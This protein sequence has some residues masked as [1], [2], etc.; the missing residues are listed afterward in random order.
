MK[1]FLL[2]LSLLE[3]YAILPEKD[4]L[5]LLGK[6]S[7]KNI[8]QKYINSIQYDPKKIIDI[9]SEYDFPYNYNFIE[10]SKIDINIKNQGSCNCSWS[11]A[12]TTSLSYRFYKKG[13]NINLSPQ[14]PLSCYIKNCSFENYLIDTQL[15]LVKNGTVSEEC[16]PY[17]SEGGKISEQCPKKCKNGSDLVKYY[18]YKPYS[19]EK[20]YSEEN[21][22][23][24]ITLIMDEL[25][26]NGPLVAQVDLYQDLIDWNKNKE[27]CIDEIYIHNIDNKLIGKYFVTIIGYG[28][29]KNKFYWLVQ[30]SLGDKN[31]ILTR[32]EFGQIGIERIAFS[33]P[34]IVKESEIKKNIVLSFDKITDSCDLIIK[35]NSLI[36]EWND[37]LEI[38][39]KNNNSND[40]FY[41]QC[42]TNKLIN[43]TEINCYYENSNINLQKGSYEFDNYKSS[44]KNNVFYLDESFKY[45]KFNFYGH[46]E[47]NYFI[48]KNIYVS[49]KGSQIILNNIPNHNNEMIIPKIYPNI[50]SQIELSNCKKIELNKDLK[51]NFIFC[52]L[53]DLEIKYF[54]YIKDNYISYN[55]LCGQ[56]VETQ[57]N[58]HKL[59]LEKYPRFTIKKIIMPNKVVFTRFD[60]FSIYADIEGKISFKENKIIGFY[61]LAY[62]DDIKYKEINLLECTSKNILGNLY[63]NECQFECNVFIYDSSAEEI[64]FLP[65][66]FYNE[67]NTPYEIIMESGIKAEKISSFSSYLKASL[68]LF[69]SILLI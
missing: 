6:I 29:Q 17:N 24:I 51:F 13:I 62:F 14:Y 23:D 30:N 9:I 50:K 34:Y 1:V 39:F 52:N 21:F 8:E 40:K 15:N 3:I 7:E 67:I 46:N 58:V 31:C 33:E 27:K 59:N 22:Y 69:L 54:D 57:L 53:T 44:E 65:Y 2:I 26:T 45:K 4:K 61:L 28:Y 37:T 18:S 68:F 48:S 36:D 38:N 42:N 35:N 5:I 64:E 43:K 11:F 19:T 32:I 12:S 10:E 20:Y 63:D 66:I 25:I 16:A 41:Y 47:L 60:K 49:K 56:K 55:V